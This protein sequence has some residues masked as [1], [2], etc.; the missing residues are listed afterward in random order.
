VLVSSRDRGA[1]SARIATSV[2]IGFIA[3]AELDGDV[4]RALLSSGGR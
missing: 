1:Y 3:K 4:L 2:A